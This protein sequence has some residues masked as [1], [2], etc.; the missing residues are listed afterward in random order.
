MTGSKN[1]LVLDMILETVGHNDFVYTDVPGVH[2]S[3]LKPLV[4]RG[5]L[6][7]VR[8]GH[9]S[10]G[11]CRHQPTVYRVKSHVKSGVSGGD[12]E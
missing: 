10:N 4:N 5:Y 3:S 12:S 2:S 9:D 8:R 7:V 6:A 11:D 1:P